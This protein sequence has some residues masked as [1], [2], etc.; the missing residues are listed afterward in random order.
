LAKSSHKLPSLKTVSRK[1]AQ[2]RHHIDGIVLS[3]SGED[4]EATIVIGGLLERAL[5]GAL[6]KRLRKL[7]P[8]ETN[9]IFHQGALSTLSA[10][11]N[12]AY[13]LGIIGPETRTD[14][15]TIKDVRNVFAHSPQ[16][17]TFLNRSIVHRCRGLH[18]YKRHIADGGCR[19][20]AREAFMQAARIYVF[21]LAFVQG[22]RMKVE[23]GVGELQH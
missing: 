1:P 17:V 7:T 4:R 9:D 10:K 11:I 21:L 6:K 8:T 5:D 12:L 20:S 13:A 2:I 18:H 15:N 3:V 23:A 22:P 19:L 14:L 16:D